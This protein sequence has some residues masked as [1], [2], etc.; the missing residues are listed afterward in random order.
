MSIFD[1]GQDYRAKLIFDHM[2]TFMFSAL[3]EALG[4]VRFIQV[5]ANDGR[6]ADPVQAFVRSERWTGVLVE[7]IPDVFS[8]LRDALSL[9][10]GLS[11]ANCAI[12]PQDGTATF[13]ACRAPHSPLSSFDRATI[14]KHTDWALSIG[15]PAPETCIEEI[16]VPVF[17]LETLCTKFGIDKVDV[18]VT[19][20][21]G[22]DCK[23]IQSMALSIRRPAIIYFEHT[24]CTDGETMALRDLLASLNY[25]LLC[26]KY[27]AIAVQ[28]RGVF[29]PSM[30]RM[31]REILID[32]SLLRRSLEKSGPNGLG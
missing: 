12:G 2:A 20:T 6:T 17:T 22:F 19:D 14:L 29:D 27:N 16:S 13:Y 11:F 1:M 28:C 23:V 32:A 21:E 4:L 7:P 5:G 25:H 24:H 9:I 3:T 15:L 10:H 30:I 31:F 8:K 26:D 18:L